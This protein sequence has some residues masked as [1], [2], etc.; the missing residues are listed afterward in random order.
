MTDL[1]RLLLVSTCLAITACGFLDSKRNTTSIASTSSNEDKRGYWTCQASETGDDW[2]CLQESR[3]PIRPVPARQLTLDTLKHDPVFSS[4]FPMPPDSQ[5]VSTDL[6]NTDVSKARDRSAL[7]SEP[8]PKPKPKSRIERNPPPVEPHERPGLVEHPSDSIALSELPAD[9]YTVQIIATSSMEA[10]ESF[11][12]EHGLR[13]SLS[14][15][16]EANGNFYY[17]LLLGAYETLSD[18]R[19]AAAS[20][21]ESLM[22]IEPWVRKLGSLQAAVARANVVTSLVDS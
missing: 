9:F 1:G 5:N 6:R 4:D 17:V 13:D 22:S 10:L 18:A 7:P 14:A 16:V 20:R 19:A 21:P 15:R 12:K 11:T 8:A 3:L 2:D